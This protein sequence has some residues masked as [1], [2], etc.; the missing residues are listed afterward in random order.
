MKTLLPTWLV[1]AG[2][3]TSAPDS[4]DDTADSDTGDT[5]PDTG[6][7]TGDSDTGGGADTGPD[8]VAD[9][10][11]SVHGELD[12]LVLSVALVNEQLSVMMALFG[13]TPVSSTTELD[14]PYVDDV[15]LTDA[16]KYQ[17][18]LFVLAAH[19]DADGDDRWDEGETFVATCPELL[20]YLRGELTNDFVHV[21][22]VEGWNAVRT[23][24]G[25]SVVVDPLDL[26]ID[27]RSV[28]TL[29]LSGTFDASIAPTD[30]VAT[31]ALQGLDGGE[32]DPLADRSLTDGTW[33]IT[34]DGPPPASH[35]DDLYGIGSTQALEFFAAYTDVE[36]DGAFGPTDTLLGLGCVGEDIAA[37]WWVEPFADPVAMYSIGRDLAMGW[38]AHGHVHNSG[39]GRW[40]VADELDDVLLSTDCQMD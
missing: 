18:G 16:G 20:V 7:D 39:V 30:R 40:L 23:E 4:A 17:Y 11:A 26:D 35:L 6:G 33:S 34:L 38:N 8:G 28:D 3:A 1:L 22:F 25:P 36:P 32:S 10:A 19:R 29:T 14:L 12:G 13:E 2:C 31:L 37:A 21:G 27:V 24:D 15:F 9:V 5:G